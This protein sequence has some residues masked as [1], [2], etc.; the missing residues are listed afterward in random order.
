MRRF[1]QESWQGIPFTAFSH[2][3]FFHLADPKFYATFYE[4]LFRRYQGWND[5][6]ATWRANKAK[7]ARWLAERIRDIVT[8]ERESGEIPADGPARVLSIGSGVGYMEKLLLE[9]LPD[10]ELHV[11]EPSTVGMRW[12][13]RLIPAERI[14][15][16]LPPACLPPDVRYDVIYLSAVDYGIPTRELVHVLEELRSQLAPGGGA[17]LPFRLAA[18]GG[19]V[20][21]QLCQCHQ[22]PHPRRSPLPRHQA[23][24]VLGLAAYPPGISPHLRPGGVQRHRGRHPG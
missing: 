8:R 5:L 16:G 3:S 21:R 20:H 22:D 1:Y 14:Y 18:G 24:T 7:D 2:I 13:R 12:L 17:D 6:P 10:V 23:A 19:F 9:E 4:E 11:N 15:I